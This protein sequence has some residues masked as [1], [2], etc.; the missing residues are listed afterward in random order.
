MARKLAPY[1]AL[2]ATVALWDSPTEWFADVR[3]LK[4]LDKGDVL[5]RIVRSVE[6]I[7]GWNVAAK[8]LRSGRWKLKASTGHRSGNVGVIRE[9]Y[10]GCVAVHAQPLASDL[11]LDDAPDILPVYY[12][13]D[14]YGRAITS[15]RKRRSKAA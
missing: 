13:N 3:V 10:E 7:G 12:G 11:E 15:R 5:V 1:P 9:Q 4:R 2:G 8:I 14:E 6:R